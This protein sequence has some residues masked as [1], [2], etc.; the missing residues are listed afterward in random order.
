M[1]P[2]DHISNSKS[3]LNGMSPPSSKHISGHSASMN[4]YKAKPEIENRRQE[5]EEDLDKK[6]ADIRKKYS[7]YNENIK[8]RLSDDDSLGYRP[9]GP[10]LRHMKS[11]NYEQPPLTTEY[12]STY[13]KSQIDNYMQEPP[14]LALRKQATMY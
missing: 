9:S 4:H 8:A 10:A 11:M 12:P 14:R 6:I 13:L 5:P 2:S 7:E 1:R 3:Y